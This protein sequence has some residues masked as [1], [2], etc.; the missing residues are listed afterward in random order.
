MKAAPGADTDTRTIDIGGQ[1]VGYTLRRTKRRRSIAL[2]IDERGLRVAAPLGAPQIDIDRMLQNNAAWVLR[3]IET[4]QYRRPSPLQW[5][6]GENLYFLGRPLTLRWDPGALIP[7]ITENALLVA[8]ATPS[9]PTVEDRVRTLFRAEAL[10]LFTR[11][12]ADFSAQRGLPAPVVCLSD[13][14][15][16]WGSCHTGGRIRMQW[17]L[18]Q[19]PPEWIDYVAAHEV[20]HLEQMNHSAAFWRVVAALIPDHAERRAAL[21]RDAHRYLLL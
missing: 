8:P 13:A 2:L 16:R 6:A 12:C 17:R 7:R 4:W 1:P 10:A 11:R 5:Q 15:T 3:K 21:R 19:T 20:A 9:A 18:I 14:H